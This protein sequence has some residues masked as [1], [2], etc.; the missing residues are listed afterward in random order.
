MAK[1]LAARL[2]AREMARVS[3]VTS[4]RIGRD[5]NRTREQYLAE[6]WQTA[7]ELYPAK[8]ED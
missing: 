1:S 8:V 5:T 2:T 7:R 4:E 3:R 6:L